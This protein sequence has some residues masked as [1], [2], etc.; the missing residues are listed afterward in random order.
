M[1]KTDH[2]NNQS[3]HTVAVAGFYCS[4]FFALKLEQKFHVKQDGKYL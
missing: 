4:A 2:I 3:G 1:A